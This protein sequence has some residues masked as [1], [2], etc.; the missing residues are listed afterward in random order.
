[1]PEQSG[2]PARDRGSASIEAAIIV[3][4]LIMLLCLFVAAGRLALAGQN[5]D[6][7]AED[8]ARAASLA[9]TT[10]AAGSAAHAAAADSLGNQGQSCTSNRVETDTSGLAAPL[11]QAASVTVQVS[12]TVP[13]GD[14][15]LP[16]AGGPGTHT[17]TAS[18]SSVVDQ[19]RERS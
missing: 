10:E 7:A 19:F 4:L 17:V 5:A 14:L 16:G 18:F 9:R 3:P 13:L 2:W 8:A 1:M 6:A 12:C 15:L 11:G